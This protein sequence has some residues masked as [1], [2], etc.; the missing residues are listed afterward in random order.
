[1]STTTVIVLCVVVPLLLGGFANYFA[2]KWWILYLPLFGFI[3]LL[4]Y[5]GHL[6]ITWTHAPNR[7]DN[8]KERPRLWIKA[9]DAHLENFNVPR[10]PGAP[11]VEVTFENTSSVAA[12]NLEGKTY[13]LK[14]DQKL[15][16]VPPQPEES[17]KQVLPFVPAH[18]EITQPIGTSVDIEPDL[19]GQIESEKIFM[20]VFGWVTYKSQPTDSK[21]YKLS[22]CSLYLPK[23]NRFLR[24]RFG[25]K[26]E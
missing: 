25:N 13:L 24:T 5:L 21:N 18:H 8:E 10:G 6:A 2:H 15:T 19:K 4:G 23:S 17:E 22:F 7:L 3:I 14:T 16:E 26:D 9:I 20:Y 12:F 1:M 11:I